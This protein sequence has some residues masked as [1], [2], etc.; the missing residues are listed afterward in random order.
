MMKLEGREFQ[1]YGEHER[2]QVR[3]G[4]KRFAFGISGKECVPLFCF[5]IAIHLEHQRT[6]PKK[7]EGWCLEN[8][9]CR[10]TDRILG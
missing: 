9:H 7:F 5:Q 4:F 10:I 6:A 8:L 1:K 2:D 3:F